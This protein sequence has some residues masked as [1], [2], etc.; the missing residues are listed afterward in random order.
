MKS[1][2]SPIRRA[3]RKPALRPLLGA[4]LTVLAL[5]GC[6]GGSH[7][8]EGDH[9]PPPS[10]P[11]TYAQRCLLAPAPSTVPELPA[12]TGQHCI[13]KARFALSDP[14]RPE[15]HTSEPNDSRELAIRIWYPAAP[16]VG[17][18]RAE[19][20]DPVLLPLI[21]TDFP[22]QVGASGLATANA[23]SD[24]ALPSG[25]KYPVIL[26]SPGYGGN[27]DIYT[28]LLEDLAS[29]GHVVVAID[30]AYLSGPVRLANGQVALTVGPSSEQD[31]QAF[32]QA[33]Q[34]T[35]VEDQRQVLDW[36]Q[37]QNGAG[38]LA[39]HLD[40][41]HVGTFGHSLGG[42]AAMWT[43]RGDARVSSAL[44]I[45]GLVWGDLSGA[46]P[47]P[48]GFVIGGHAETPEVDALQR[49]NIDI[50]MRN[51]TG[52]KSQATV[53]GA[54]HLDFSDLK[55]LVNFYAPNLPEAELRELQLGPIDASTA[56]RTSRQLVREFFQ[57]A[58]KP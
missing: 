8:D 16:A 9:R 39:G 50:L 11:L 23:K 38:L 28:T 56:L 37:T 55:L 19:Y 1:Q 27:V 15:P 10:P 29:Q 25:A 20:F 4:G 47:K 53:P 58:G 51:A 18:Q 13:G 45:D 36:L 44:D 24:A 7:D 2:L 42:A 35:L 31:R 6:G 30:H 17:G 5:A 40:L 12:P 48:I 57:N 33:A 41:A 21:L 22:I 26:F 32:F 52:P 54:A 14:H 3:S 43:A 34:S 49:G 46:W